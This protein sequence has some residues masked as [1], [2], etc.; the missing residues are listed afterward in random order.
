M[1]FILIIKITTVEEAFHNLQN[2]ALTRSK[3]GTGFQKA[4]ITVKLHLGGWL[5]SCFATEHTYIESTEVKSVLENV[6]AHL[7]VALQLVHPE[8][9][10]SE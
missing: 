10:A 7:L 5:T 2:S 1:L 8:I 6:F 4:S 9:V 3:K